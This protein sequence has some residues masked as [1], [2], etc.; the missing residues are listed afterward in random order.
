MHDVVRRAATSKDQQRAALK[1]S[2][3]FLFFFCS[4]RLD[5]L[6]ISLL[7][8]WASALHTDGSTATRPLRRNSYSTGCWDAIL[9]CLVCVSCS[10]VA[11]P[12]CLTGP[13]VV[14]SIHRHMDV[15]G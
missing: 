2:L 7:D 13:L 5:Y 6:L 4:Y 9:G 11:V 1:V 14:N 8:V 3:L 15:C 10:S 12:G